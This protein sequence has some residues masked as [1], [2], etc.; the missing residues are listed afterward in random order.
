VTVAGKTTSFDYYPA[1]Q[2]GAGLLKSTL[3][4]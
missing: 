1:G 4:L 2:A 3:N